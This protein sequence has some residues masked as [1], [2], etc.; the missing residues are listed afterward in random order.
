MK[1]LS[2]SHSLSLSPTHTHTHTHTH[3]LKHTLSLT[4]TQRY[5]EA[6]KEAGVIEKEV[7]QLKADFDNQESYLE[8]RAEV[9]KYSILIY[10]TLLYFILFYSIFL[11]YEIFN[12]YKLNK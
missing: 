7:S 3:T 1:V 11:R 9:S 6:K 5:E 8:G 10:F 12:K 4:H 2:V